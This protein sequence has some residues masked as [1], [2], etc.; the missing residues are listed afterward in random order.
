MKSNVNFHIK[1]TIFPLSFQD[2]GRYGFLAQGVPISGAMDLESAA[3]A[4]R[5]VDNSEV[6]PVLEITLSGS[7]ISISNKCQIAITG[8]NLSSK[9][10]NKPVPMWETITIEKPSILTFEKVISGCRAYLAFN[11][12]WKIEPWLKSYSA[13]AQSNLTPQFVFKKGDSID[14]TSNTFISKKIYPEKYRPSFP[15]AQKIKVMEGPEFNSFTKTQIKYFLKKGFKIASNSNRMG[16]NLAAGFKNY[17]QKKELISSGVVPG[18]IQVTNSG[19]LTIL[20]RDAQTTGGYPR[21]AQILSEDINKVGQ[22][23]A[24][25]EIFF[26]MVSL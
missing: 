6:N 4:N 5:L 15:V 8:A 1:K 16:Y 25:D 21:I 24:G 3:I 7:R 26:E 13:I 20:M 18:T 14:A 23:K 17:K 19:Q 9:I 12:N 2:A 22:M 10:N 11:G